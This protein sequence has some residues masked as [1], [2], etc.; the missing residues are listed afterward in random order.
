[1]H[2]EVGAKPNNDVLRKS[3]TS[4]VNKHDQHA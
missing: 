2:A 1:M 4:Y 3:K